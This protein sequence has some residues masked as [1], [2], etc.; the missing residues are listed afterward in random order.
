MLKIRLRYF[1][2]VVREGSVRKAAERLHVAASAVNRQILQLE[3]ELGVPLFE[4]LPRGM[5]P[6]AAGEILLSYVRRWHNEEGKLLHQLHSLAGGVRGTVRI[7]APEAMADVLLPVALKNLRARF[8]HVD[9]AIVTGDSFHI[10]RELLWHEADFGLAFN[11]GQTKGVRAIA[12]YACPW[13]VLMVPGH[14]LAKRQRLTLSEC[15]GHPLIL[16]SGDWFEQSAIK[17]LIRDTEVP[18]DV[19]G[20]AERPSVVKSLTR[21]G[22][23]MAFMT[24]LEAAYE[25][26]HGELV[27]VPLVDR[28][29]APSR[30]FLL[31]PNRNVPVF[32]APVI[33]EVKLA[34]ACLK[35]SEA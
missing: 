31:T 9:F 24:R 19:A 1:E 21:A 17:R 23:G 15:T 18:L 2:G 30:L 4:R 35:E 28:G 34:L 25:I 20:R 13:G 33:E 12:S 10:L 27:Y 6:S 7:A 11:I 29:M 26:E 5:R 8:P 3:E 14:P 16:P 22:V 32:A